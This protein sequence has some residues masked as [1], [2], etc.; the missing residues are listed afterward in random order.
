MR[1][2][3]IAGGAGIAMTREAS[4]TSIAFGAVLSVLGIFAVLAP[5]FTGVAVTVLVGLLLLLAGVV[6]IVFAFGAK[7]LG[8]GIVKFLLGGFSALAGV[9]LLM[10]PVE[11]LGTLTIILA[12]FFVAGG[13]IDVILALRLKPEE[14]WGWMVFS[15]IVS[16]A[17]G[18][19]IL[20]QWPVSGIWAVG[21]LVGVRILMNGWMLMA[22]GRTGQVM[23]TQ[24]QDTRIE[25]L[26]AHVRAGAQALHAAQ[27]ALAEHAAMLLILQEE[28]STKVSEAEVDPSI[29]EL[30]QKL[31]EAR[32]RMKEVAAA[33]KESWDRTQHEANDA[34]G[35]LQAQVAEATKELKEKLGLN[36]PD[37]L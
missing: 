27:A 19:F 11:S 29:K 10:T 28:L 3:E 36:D 33:T 5:L 12:V 34:F 32:V 35:E 8:K 17:L 26:E 15:G 1:N 20:S 4:R 7:S 30:N 6:Q 37:E 23:L 18:V 25:M 2:G 13:I 24:L 21:L 9:I 16:A 31:G 14:G 22:L